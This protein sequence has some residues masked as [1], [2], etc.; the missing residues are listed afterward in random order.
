MS[1]GEGNITIIRQA[2]AISLGEIG[3]AFEIA[4]DGETKQPILLDE[5]E[6]ATAYAQLAANAAQR[7]TRVLKVTEAAFIKPQREINPETAS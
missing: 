2:Y 5:I 3:D 4:R 7:P 6:Q 1:T